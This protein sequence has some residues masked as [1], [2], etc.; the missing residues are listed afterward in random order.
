M[1][2]LKFDRSLS[3]GAL[4]LILAC[5]LHF[6]NFS[7][8]LHRCAKIQKKVCQDKPNSTAGL[9]LGEINE[10]VWD[11]RTAGKRLISTSYKYS[12]GRRFTRWR[13]I[14]KKVD[15]KPLRWERRE[16]GLFGRQSGENDPLCG[17]L[18]KEHAANSKW[19]MWPTQKI[20]KYL[21]FLDLGLQWIDQDFSTFWNYML[22]FR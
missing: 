5:L 10:L 6:K 12:C 17:K 19:S 20:W 18:H 22:S 14:C 8:I 3:N 16:C 15:K 4:N 21:I 1:Y 7:D 2:Y 13:K 9:I 11:H